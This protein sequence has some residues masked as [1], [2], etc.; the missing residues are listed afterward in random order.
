MLNKI[1]SKIFSIKENINPTI[2]IKSFKDLEYFRA[3]KD[4]F[5]TLKKKN[6]QTKLMLVGGCV[7]KL[8]KDE[9]I[10]DID[11]AIN[12]N[13]KEIKDILNNNK[14]KILETGISHGTITVVFNNFKFELTTLRKDV[15][16]D[17][18]HAD[19]EFV[20]DWEIDAKRRDFT[21]NS[22]YSNLRGEIYDP[23]GGLEDLNNGVVKFIG[24]PN[25]RIREDYLRIL[26]YLRFY[27][28]YGKNEH[29]DETIKAIKINLEGLIKI[30]KERI[31]DELFKI[32]N[33]KDFKNLFKNKFSCFVI[34]SIFPQLKYYNRLKFLNKISKY[35]LKKIDPILLL[36]IILIDGSD[37]SEFFLY[38]YKL[39]NKI[40]KRILFIQENFRKKNLKDLLDEKKILKMAYSNNVQPII[41]LLIFSI[42]TKDSVNIKLVEKKINFLENIKMPIFPIEAN[43]LKTYYGFTEGVEL[44]IVLKKLKEYWIDNNFEIDKKNIKKILKIK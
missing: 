32:L 3:A 4:I 37:N 11:I 40:K 22:I 12:L 15:S 35:I 41:D 16:T 18:R 9:E 5:L 1:K 8:L 7:R 28:Q 20:S 23:L 24:D 25:K 27:T 21:I 42:F 29:S 33:L 13:P 44:G 38:K 26:R 17:G 2:N 10:D 31:V 43:Y 19:V 39:S 30:S 14:M 36:S 6:K 34:L